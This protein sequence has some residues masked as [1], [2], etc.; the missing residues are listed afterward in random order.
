[1]LINSPD[2]GWIKVPDFLVV[3]AA[4]SGTT[5]FYHLLN[6]HP[7]VFF[8]KKK[9]PF[10]FSFGGEKPQYSDLQFVANITWQ[11]KDYIDLYRK[12]G[13][14][15]V[16][17]DAS[18]SYLYHSNTCIKNIKK[19]Y[20]ERYKDLKIL[21]IL[22]NPVERAFSHYTYLIQNGFETLSFPE[23]I[24]TDNI[25]KRKKI[26]WGFDYLEYGMYYRQVKDFMETFPHCKVML[27]ED[28]SNSESLMMDVYSFLGV[29]PIGKRSEIYSNP[30]GIP[31]NSFLVKL[32]RKNK[33]LKKAANLLPAKWKHSLLLQ[34][35][36]IVSHLLVKPE[37]ERESM[38]KL[39]AY[40]KDDILNL[41]QLINRDLGHWLKK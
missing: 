4:K 34:R 5:S 26:R 39:N 8:P 22:R 15:Q 31:K 3:G 9:E 17:G 12:A 14:D 41:Q 35:D 28:L 19:F 36:K 20:G 30:S 27:T 2:N 24:S 29:K 6:Q 38:V 10:Y 13:D 11:T 21:I 25:N 7:D 23:A 16:L 40:F 1:M 18:T 33:I 37:M 32:L